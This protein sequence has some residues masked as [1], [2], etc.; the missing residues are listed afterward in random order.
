MRAAPGKVQGLYLARLPA[1]VA[2]L[3]KSAKA[4]GAR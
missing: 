3:N 1:A 2:L 4:D